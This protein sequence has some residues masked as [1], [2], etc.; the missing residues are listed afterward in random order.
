MKK[1][2]KFMLIGLS[3]ASFGLAAV[4]TSVIA[5]NGQVAMATKNEVTIT[6]DGNSGSGEM[7][8]VTIYEGDE[9]TYPECGFKCE[10]LDYVFL[11]WTKSYDSD[12]HLYKPGDK[13]VIYENTTLV[14]QWVYK[15]HFDTFIEGRVVP[16]NQNVELEFSCN[17]D[18]IQVTLFRY[19][20]EIFDYEAIDT[21]YDDDENPIAA[22]TKIAYN[23]EMQFPN[24]GLEYFYIGVTT[25]EYTMALSNYFRVNWTN[26]EY[27]FLTKINLYNYK[28]MHVN[29]FLFID[30]EINKNP[31]IYYLYYAKLGSDEFEVWTDTLGT[32]PDTYMLPP[33]EPGM[34]VYYVAALVNQEV[35]ATSQKYLFGWY[36]DAYEYYVTF[37]ANGGAG[38]MDYLFVNSFT[39]PECG[40]TAPEGYVFD[41]WDILGSEY[42]PGDTYEP[43]DFTRVYAYWKEYTREITV[44]M[45]IESFYQ[46]DE[47]AEVPFT[48]NFDASAG[49]FILQWYNN[50]E[51]IW[52][53]E[54]R[55]NGD[56]L[57][58]EYVLTAVKDDDVQLS[59]RVVYV[60]AGNIEAES[61][62]FGL[63]WRGSESNLAYVNFD[64][65][66]GSGE[67][68]TIIVSIGDEYIIPDCLFTSPSG[69]EFSHWSLSGVKVDVGTTMIIYEDITLV[70]N[71]KV[72]ETSTEVTSKSGGG[73]SSGGGSSSLGIGAIL[74]IVFGSIGGVAL[75]GAGVFFFLKYRKKNS[76]TTNE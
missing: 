73:E 14:A 62:T 39:F 46:L 69:Y 36:S 43:Y 66:G 60:E 57:G 65:N 55:V 17:V 59:Y 19:N 61:D 23:L 3:I 15:D 41:H 70:A 27:Y 33:G 71:W 9:Y 4:A 72:V 24:G 40:F 21:F 44:D 5:N 51:D 34:Y 22:G 7:K 56:V 48:A 26:D 68:I 18:A 20:Y 52:V 76:S 2:N 75:I 53:D 47:V 38:S 54:T 31:D 11:G 74:G 50:S 58:T 28:R 1:I 25:P 35:V 37:D 6:F 30:W 10:I 45:P 63:Y 16:L 12:D 13:E 32:R 42:Q 64:A 29:D 67:M 8:S 49:E